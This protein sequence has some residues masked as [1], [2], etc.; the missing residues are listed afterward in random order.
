MRCW[1]SE[2]YRIGFDLNLFFIFD[3]MSNYNTIQPTWSRLWRW[4]QDERSPIYLMWYI[5]MLG[6]SFI[7][8]K[9]YIY[10]HHLFSCLTSFSVCSTLEAT[11]LL[12]F[13]LCLQF[14]FSLLI[15]KDIRWWV[16]GKGAKLHKRPYG[17]G[18]HMGYFLRKQESYHIL[19]IVKHLTYWY[20]DD[21]NSWAVISDTKL[22]I[23]S[24]SIFLRH[25]A[26]CFGLHAYNY[27]YNYV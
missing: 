4:L 18:I 26:F 6:C 13:N 11:F 22:V 23:L 19:D 9:K 24:P 14:V 21:S 1:A 12:C 8:R 5:K 20:D 16:R 25:C 2:K 17:I 3:V 27:M 7:N 10:F 15:L